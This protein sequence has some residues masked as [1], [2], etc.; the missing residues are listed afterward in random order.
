MLLHNLTVISSYISKLECQFMILRIWPSCA[1][2][3]WRRSEM[4][5]DLKCGPFWLDHI[6]NLLKKCSKVLSNFSYFDLKC[7]SKIW[8]V[9]QKSE[10]WFKNLKC[11]SKFWNV[12][13]AIWNV[14]GARAAKMDHISDPA[15]IQ[16]ANFR[17]KWDE[18]KSRNKVSDRLNRSYLPVK[19]AIFGAY[20][21]HIRP[22]MCESCRWFRK[23]S[24]I[25]K[26]DYKKRREAAF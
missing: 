13:E 8:N 10:M 26:K 4:W 1:H 17:Q 23:P 2:Q 19:A 14:A 18:P 12:A 24:A 15:T 25:V 5:S 22:S 16:I 7:G 20:H 6:S 9:A 11:G 21:P 3:W